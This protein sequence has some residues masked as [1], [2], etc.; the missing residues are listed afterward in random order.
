MK[1]DK[2]KWK[3]DFSYFPGALTVVFA[4]WALA[5]GSFLLA[6]KCFQVDFTATQAFSV[7]S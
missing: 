6:L 1:I 3:Y 7:Y 5:P 4:F 2:E